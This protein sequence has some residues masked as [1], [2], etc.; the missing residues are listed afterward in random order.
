[1]LEENKY[2][3]I[4]KDQGN[5]TICVKTLNRSLYRLYNETIDRLAAEGKNV[6]LDFS[7]VDE[8]HTISSISSYVVKCYQRLQSKGATLSI[9]N[10]PEIMAE[11]LGMNGIHNLVTIRYKPSLKLE[12]VVYAS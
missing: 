2:F 10:P 12:K 6:D 4:N 1:M 9:T 8:E 7:N 3:T 11:V 5:S